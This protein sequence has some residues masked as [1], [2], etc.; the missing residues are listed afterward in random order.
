MSFKMSY[1]QLQR[2]ID[3]QM[4]MKKLMGTAVSFPLAKSLKKLN[5]ALSRARSEI[6]GAYERDFLKVYAKHDE[7]GKMVTRT[8]DASQFVL[9]EGKTEGDVEKACNDFWERETT[10]DGP[11]IRLSELSEIKFTAMELCALDPICSDL[12]MADT[13]AQVTHLPPASTL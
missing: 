8:E 3:F 9:M 6:Q 5:Q 12:E 2:D 1:K 7:Q 11:K 13:P 10:V 4:A